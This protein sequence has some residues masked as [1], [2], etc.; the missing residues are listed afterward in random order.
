M[1]AWVC[2]VRVDDV[3]AIQPKGSH[4]D[5]LVAWLLELGASIDHGVLV[6]LQAG[7]QYV[8]HLQLSRVLLFVRDRARLER[9]KKLL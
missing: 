7:L 4:F 5:L 3:C 1:F 9:E 6:Q 2:Q 8:L